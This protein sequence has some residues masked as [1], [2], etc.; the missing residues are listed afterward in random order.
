MERKKPKKTEEV[1]EEKPVETDNKEINNSKDVGEDKKDEA[2]TIVD[3]TG[4]ET[5]E[6]METCP[7]IKDEFAKKV[8]KDIYKDVND[9]FR[10]KD[11]TKKTD[12]E[13]A[14]NKITN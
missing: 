2:T 13:E 4:D 7:T 8:S 10:I 11:E 1:P 12:A 6:F 9:R 3:L 14:M 5:N